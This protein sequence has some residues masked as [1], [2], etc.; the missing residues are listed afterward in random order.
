MSDRKDYMEKRVKDLRAEILS[1]R[2][3]IECAASASWAKELD[4]DLLGTKIDEAASAVSDAEKW[5]FQ[6]ADHYVVYMCLEHAAKKKEEI[7]EMLDAAEGHWTDRLEKRDATE[8]ETETAQI[9]GGTKVVIPIY[10]TWSQ[11][12]GLV[13]I[14][15]V[16]LTCFGIPAGWFGVEQ[17]VQR[18]YEDANGYV[19]MEVEETPGLIRG[20]F[21]EGGPY[22]YVR[23]TE[24][25]KST[26]YTYPDSRP[27]WMSSTY[28]DM[29]KGWAVEKAVR[30]QGDPLEVTDENR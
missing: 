24:E 21:R 23:R 5:F 3:E 12:K 4:W 1:L 30:D 18:I 10:P 14:L 27:V 6:N 16:F 20:L 29:M 26:W 11:A 17:D 19:I 22:V 25:D 15:F 9:V 28:E 7:R 13:L 2:Q 8:N